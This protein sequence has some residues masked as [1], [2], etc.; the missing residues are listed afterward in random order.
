VISEKSPFLTCIKLCRL[1]KITDQ[2]IFYL[3]HCIY[4]K[5]I[6][7]VSCPAVTDKGL[8]ALSNNCIAI[9]KLNVRENKQLTDD[10]IIKTLSR[11]HTTL[12]YVNVSHLTFLRPLESLG[13]LYRTGSA[14]QHL[15]LSHTRVDDDTIIKIVESCN[16]IREL[17]L[18]STKVTETGILAIAKHCPK[19]KHL[20]LSFLH[21]RT[22]HI[23]V[24]L[25][26]GCPELQGLEM[27]Y[28]R[29]V[30][31]DESLVLISEWGH[32]LRTLNLQGWEDITREAVEK[33]IH[34]CVNLANLNMYAVK[35]IPKKDKEELLAMLDARN[36]FIE[37]P[38]DRH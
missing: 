34:A 10:T 18:G 21:L 9:H 23:F 30:S 31:C 33:V 13:G 28:V 3:S 26:S 36:S 15:D 7:I 16:A 32:S 17:A 1:P 5:K 25:R 38:F 11:H 29:E 19:L 22:P 6:T 14:L 35:C 24:E 4:I 12:E 20:E 2:G 8:D 27:P 37:K